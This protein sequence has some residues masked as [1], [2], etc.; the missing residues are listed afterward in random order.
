MN[1]YKTIFRIDYVPTLKFYDG[2]Y[3]VS[4]KFHGYPDWWTD[5]L[6][7]TLQNFELHCSL[8]LAHSSCVYIQDTKGN[9][10]E[11]D[12]RVREAIEVATSS[13]GV[14][15]YKR[16]GFRRMYLHEASMKFEQLVS[17]FADKFLAQNQEI[18]AGICP[19]PEDVAYVVDFAD[20]SAKIKLRAGPVKREELELHLQ[21]DTNNNF[22]P[23][24]RCMAGAEI[25][26]DCPEV[27]LFIDLDY[28]REAVHPSQA[29][30]VY[31]EALAFHEKLGNNIVNYLFALAR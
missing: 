25:Y 1:Y 24:Q 8:H 4:Q 6:R 11:D 27:G 20:G 2:L 7:V 3:S 9:K 22:P 30:Q 13:M 10:D 18:R 16:F 29:L 31:N 21:P 26:A 5:R 23:K 15:E 14:A 12:Q 19:D 17:L 28:S